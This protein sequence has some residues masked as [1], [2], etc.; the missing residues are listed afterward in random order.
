MFLFKNPIYPFGHLPPNN[1]EYLP[2]LLLI[3]VSVGL[4]LIILGASYFLSVQ[5]PDSEKTSVYE[6]G[7]DPYEDSRNV[8]DI[9]FYIV[10]ILFVVFDLEAM[11]LFP[12]AV[13]L[14]YAGSMG[15]WSMFDFLLEL[16]VGFVYVW[17]VGA[18]EWT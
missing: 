15:F 8:F 9:R 14:P 13:S 2:I 3:F 4:A 12:W 17:K 16:T 18:L 1:I 11:F 10:A 6:C 5:K 7:F